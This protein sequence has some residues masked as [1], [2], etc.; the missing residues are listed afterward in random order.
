MSVMRVLPQ[1]IFCGAA[2]LGDLPHAK[3]QDL[4]ELGPNVGRVLLTGT[5]KKW[6]HDA[7]DAR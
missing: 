5:C 4:Q 1:E 3:L 7:C 6:L 2:G